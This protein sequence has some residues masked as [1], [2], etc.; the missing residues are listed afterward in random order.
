MTEYEIDLPGEI[1]LA[2]V[3]TSIEITKVSAATAAVRAVITMT[4]VA[5]GKD[6]DEYSSLYSFDPRNE[7]KAVHDIT[8]PKG[9]RLRFEARGYDSKGTLTPLH[10]PVLTVTAT[11]PRTETAEVPLNASS[12]AFRCTQAEAVAPERSCCAIS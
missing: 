7:T 11:T 2:D 8:L 3:A 1:I 4:L 10:R 5:N 12:E 6:D 9:S